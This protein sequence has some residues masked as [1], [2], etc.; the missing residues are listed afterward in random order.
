MANPF[1][2][3]I[4]REMPLRPFMP[5]DIAVESVII[6]RGE[7]P[8]QL[9]GVQL[10]EG[11]VLGLKNGLLQGVTA[12]AGGSAVDAVAYEQEEAATTWTVT[13]NRNNVNVV[14]NVYDADGNWFAP[15]GLKVTANTVVVD[16]LEAQAGRVVL[17]FIPA[18]PEEPA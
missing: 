17:I 9:A 10:T 14:V 8:R 12:G 5:S 15:N 18:T 6:R 16:V 13:H 2:D 3:F 7:G 4:Q 1:E 11:Q